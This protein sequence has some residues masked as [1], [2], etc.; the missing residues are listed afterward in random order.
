MVLCRFCQVQPTSTKRK[1]L[2]V[3][4]ESPA[5]NLRGATSGD[6]APLTAATAQTEPECTPANFSQMKEELDDARVRAKNVEDAQRV[7]ESKLE[8]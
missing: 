7:L 8:A 2:P 3:E 4:I 6:E 1:N 5:K